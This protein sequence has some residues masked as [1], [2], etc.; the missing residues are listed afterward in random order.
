M[1]L[2]NSFPVFLLVLVRIAGFLV[3]MPIFSYRTI[4]GRVKI[5]LAVALSLLVDLTLFENQTVPLDTTYILLV[6][7]ES[8]VGLSMGFIAGVLAYAVQLA[9]SFIDL[10]MGF[11]IAN[12]ISPENGI[13]T[14]LTGQLLYIMQLL[15][16]LGVNAHHMLL[17]GLLDSF[18]LIPL[19][20]LTVPFSGGSAAEYAARVTAQMFLIALQLSMPIVGCLFLVDL[21]IGLVARTVPQVNV[22]VVG[23][24]LKIIVGFLIMLI[25]FPMFI[26]LFRVIF[27]SMTE[28]L[29]HYMQLLGS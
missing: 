25:A 23:L 3:T 6:M 26:S 22:F 19:D 5:G 24:P 28:I 2:L 13:T 14:P 9:G 17:S 7:K 27:E 18:R 29:G 8:L 11:A 4:P 10:Q 12:T 20:A 21:A 1:N 16:F 15:F